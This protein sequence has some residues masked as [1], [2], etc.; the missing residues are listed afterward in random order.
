VASNLELKCRCTSSAELHGHARRLGAAFHATL[1]QTDTYFHVPRGRLKLRRINGTH[2]EL[3]QY[4]RPDEQG[5]RWSTYTRV[6]VGEPDVLAAALGNALG[7]RCVV[8]KVRGVY[9]YKT[10]RIH[11]DEVAGLGSFLEFEVVETAPAEAAEL[12]A[13]LKTAFLVRD[14]D[15]IAG[16]YGEMVKYPKVEENPS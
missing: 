6:A 5:D 1:T 2:A 16:S 8:E 13:E 9:L 12:M 3:I 14:E 15:V 7:I 11:I 10:A 4:D